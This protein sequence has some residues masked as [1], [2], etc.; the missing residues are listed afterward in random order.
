[1]QRVRIEESERSSLGKVTAR[2]SDGPLE[3]DMHENP[4]IQV[5][6]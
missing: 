5:I 1:M 4:R 2:T 3:E 6:H